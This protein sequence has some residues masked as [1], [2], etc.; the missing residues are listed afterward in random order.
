MGPD[1][2]MGVDLMLQF[3]NFDSDAR[4]ITVFR[5]GNVV[6]LHHDQ[7]MSNNC[8]QTRVYRK[9]AIRPGHV[10]NC[11]L[12]RAYPKTVSRPGH[13]VGLSPTGH[14]VYCVPTWSCREAM[15]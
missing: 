4:R 5:P 2:Q 10:V 1:C 3:L 8:I 11:V 13:I 6:K 7:G 15:S 9:L 12:T 14:V